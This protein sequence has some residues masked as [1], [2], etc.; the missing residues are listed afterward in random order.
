[1]QKFNESLVT[2]KTLSKKKC[3]ST[4]KTS[5]KISKIVANKVL[6]NLAKLNLSPD[7]SSVLK[8][9]LNHFSSTSKFN[10]NNLAQGFFDLSVDTS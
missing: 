7:V 8:L 3:N 4:A 10:K 1:M 2:H 9:A 5:I 6:I